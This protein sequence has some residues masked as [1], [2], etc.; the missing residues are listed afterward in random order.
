MINPLEKIRTISKPWIRRR[1]PT[2][3]LGFAGTMDPHYQWTTI[4]DV[5]ALY[6]AAK[7]LE[8]KGIIVRIAWSGDLFDLNRLLIA[9]DEIERTQFDAFVFVC[10]PVHEDILPLVERFAGTRRIAVGVSVPAGFDPSC[11]FDAVLA[12][13]SQ[14]GTTFDLALADIGYPHLHIDPRYRRQDFAVCT[15][16]PQGEYK[17]ACFYTADAL[18]AEASQGCDVRHV[19]TLLRG[20]ACHPCVAEMELQLSQILVTT[21]MHGALISA[22]HGAPAIVVDQIRGGA[23]VSRVAGRAGLPVINAWDT[24]AKG[25][26]ALMI[27]A[28]RRRTEIASDLIGV[29][30]T[31]VRLSREALD[32]ATSTVVAAVR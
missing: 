19:Q 8:S 14:E 26:R 6:N 18:I 28:L 15:V 16:G 32:A 20:D 5:M 21:R 2:V 3:I 11:C 25:L 29:R 17:D 23:K 12:R 30:A 7:A 24:D 9:D 10:G 13:D 4:G 1:N 31:I 22:F 27:D